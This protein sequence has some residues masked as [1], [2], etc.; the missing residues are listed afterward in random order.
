[1]GYILISTDGQRFYFYIYA[2]AEIYKSIYGGE[3]YVR[4]ETGKI[5]WSDKYARVKYG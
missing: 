3:I 5:N 1:M 4:D 2:C